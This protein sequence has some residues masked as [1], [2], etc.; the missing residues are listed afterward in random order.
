M[1][2]AT[3]TNSEAFGGGGGGDGQNGQGIQN[4]LQQQLV[5]QLSQQLSHHMSQKFPPNDLLSALATVQAQMQPQQQQQP[6]PQTVPVDI[7]GL[8]RH[9]NL[10]G[11]LSPSSNGA[12]FDNLPGASSTAPSD[13]PTATASAPVA[14]AS[15]A[16]GNN[17]GPS[18]A[19]LNK[20]LPSNGPDNPA[21][22]DTATKDERK[23]APG[24]VIVPCRARG[25]PMDHNFKVSNTRSS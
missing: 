21:T 8:A 23:K 5:H 14:T 24:S 9:A 18:G 13:A 17:D 4:S 25:M 12:T 16:N 20:G 6:Q 10:S 19:G 15:N 1:S 7:M 22:L 11:L 2:Q 3:G